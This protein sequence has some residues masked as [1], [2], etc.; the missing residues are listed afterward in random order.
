MNY[1]RAALVRDPEDDSLR[2][3][4]PFGMT[5]SIV[6]MPKNE[7]VGDEVVVAVPKDADVARVAAHNPR[8]V[9]LSFEEAKVEVEKIDKKVKISAEKPY[10]ERER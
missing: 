7:K 10:G 4:L 6:A 3:D 5:W 2:P 1:F 9:A 8:V